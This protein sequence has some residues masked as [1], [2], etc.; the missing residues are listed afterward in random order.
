[1]SSVIEHYSYAGELVRG[2]FYQIAIPFNAE[3]SFPL[4]IQPAGSVIRDFRDESERSE[5]IYGEVVADLSYEDG[6]P[7]NSSHV[8]R[9][10]YRNYRV[11]TFGGLEVSKFVCDVFG[12]RLVV[13]RAFRDELEASSLKGFTIDPLPIAINQ[14]N[15][16]IAPDLFIVRA[17]GGECH[18]LHDTRIPEPNNCP[19]CG[20]GPVVCPACKD[21]TF[22]CP[23]CKE[24]IVAPASEHRG[25]EDKRFVTVGFPPKGW[26]IEADRWDGS[27]F[28]RGLDQG[29][30]TGRLVDFALSHEAIPFVAIPCLT[31]VA[32]CDEE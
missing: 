4:P 10:Q 28:I 6:C 2:P 3:F 32:N 20:W 22:H 13:N 1:M 26:V 18:R 17:Q 31:N 7:L 19:F 27:D 29:F 16:S 11:D 12:L 21:V 9:C 8:T 25:S 14:S 5:H 15:S 24:P 30:V 23:D